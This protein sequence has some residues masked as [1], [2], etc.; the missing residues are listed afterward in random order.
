VASSLD[1][2][3]VRFYALATKLYSAAQA[4]KAAAFWIYLFY[5]L[6]VLYAATSPG[7]D[8]PRS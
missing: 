4:L 8:V 7:T 2:K 3:V 5:L 1:R 6:R